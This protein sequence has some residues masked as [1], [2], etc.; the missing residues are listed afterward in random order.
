[1]AATPKNTTSISLKHSCA[2]ARTHHAHMPYTPYTRESR[3]TPSVSPLP[4]SLLSISQHHLPVFVF[5]YCSASAARC[6]KRKQFH[7]PFL[8]IR[9]CLFQKNAP[10]Q[11]LLHCLPADRWGALVF[12]RA[13][14]GGVLKIFPCSRAG[15][16]SSNKPYCCIIQQSEVNENDIF[17]RKKRRLA[18]GRKN[19]RE[20]E[21]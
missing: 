3:K 15:Q 9:K 10:S 7:A 6:R 8:S 13:G 20:Q 18:C 5:C 2:A 19:V 4:R 11:V 1:M 21:R 12:L 17:S 14:G 16:R